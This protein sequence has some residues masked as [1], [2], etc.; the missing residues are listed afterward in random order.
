M[1]WLEEK[2]K[3]MSPEL[4]RVLRALGQLHQGAA[5]A[6]RSAL[7][8]QGALQAASLAGWTHKEIAAES[9]TPAYY[10]RAT[11]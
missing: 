6:S 8:F 2:R 11:P 5:R 3:A 4:L 7:R 1:S 10:E 9:H